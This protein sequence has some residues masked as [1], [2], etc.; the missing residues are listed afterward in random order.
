MSDTVSR[1][2]TAIG[3]L[4]RDFGGY[5]QKERDAMRDVLRGYTNQIINEAWPEQGRGRVPSAGVEWMD[6]L[7]AQL[8]A[9]SPAR[10]RRRSCMPKR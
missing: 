5:P 3:S 10:N 2:A 9:Y 8:F 7:Q 4:W 6:R 1:E